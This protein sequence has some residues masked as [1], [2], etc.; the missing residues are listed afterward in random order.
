MRLRNRKHVAIWGV[1]LVLAGAT[2][3]LIARFIFSDHWIAVTMY[4]MLGV[5][6]LV[7]YFSM[8]LVALGSGFLVFSL[9]RFDQL[10][11]RD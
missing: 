4:G 7:T 6:S 10:R 9:L 8:F 1:S 2:L 5:L 11:R 3:F